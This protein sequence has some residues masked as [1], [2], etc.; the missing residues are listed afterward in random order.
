M[1]SGTAPDCPS[2]PSPA[3]PTE[4][5]EE[6]ANRDVISRLSPRPTIARLPSNGLTHPD[7]VCSTAPSDKNSNARLAARIAVMFE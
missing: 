5:R 4:G 7:S 3:L 6:D 2:P 1:I